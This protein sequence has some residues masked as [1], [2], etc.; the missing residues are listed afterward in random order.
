MAEKWSLFVRQFV[1][2]GGYKTVV[3]GL[4]NTLIIA[5]L[6]LLIGIL[7][8]TILAVTKVVPQYKTSAKVFSKLTDIYVGFFRGTPI[9]V[10]LLLAYWVLLPAIGIKIDA[11]YVA[12]IVFGMNSGAYICE[13]MRAGINSVDRGQLEAGRSLGLSYAQSMTKIVIPQAVK[14]IFPTL[15]NEFIVLVKETSVVSFISVVD[16]TKAFRGL[17]SANYE[18]V[19]PYLVLAAIYLVIVILITIGIKLIEKRM[20]KSDRHN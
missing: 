1:E 7:L 4:E 11:L 19:V 14:N 18:Y 5:V 8:G 6:G 13:I 16:I 3:T 17:A 10:Q 15:G 20:A 2:F 12:V 9:V